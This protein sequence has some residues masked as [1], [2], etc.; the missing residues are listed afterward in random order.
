MTSTD[1]ATNAQAIFYKYSDQFVGPREPDGHPD[2]LAVLDYYPEFVSSEM[3]ID[4]WQAAFRRGQL[5]L[6]ISCR[7]SERKVMLGFYPGVKHASAVQIAL[8]N[9]GYT[10]THVAAYRQEKYRLAG[11]VL[12]PSDQS[13]A[14]TAML[15][16]LDGAPNPDEKKKRRYGP[17]KSPNARGGRWNR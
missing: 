16:N 9:G 6:I 13:H 2:L 14:G 1:D 15:K 17:Q 4:L 12:F 3:A 5:P 8:E 11:E 10:A 7:P